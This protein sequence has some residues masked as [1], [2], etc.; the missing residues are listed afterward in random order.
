[1]DW[2]AEVRHGLARSHAAIDDGV[3]EEMAQH[4]ESAWQ[5]ARAEGAAADEA[6][7]SVR[8]LIDAWCAA[9]EGPRRVRRPP[10]LASAPASSSSS[11][12]LAGIGLDVRHA[13]RLFQ[14]QRGF[15]L[16]SILMIALGIGATATI[17]S[18]VN[19]V[20]LKPLPWPNAAQLVRVSETRRGGTVSLVPELTNATYL[21][22]IEHAQTI[23]GIAGYS[24]A[25]AILS[26]DNGA[27]RVP[28]ANVTA[29][30]FPLLGVKPLL[31]AGFTTA[32]D[33][34]PVVVL[35]YG[36]WRERFGGAADV[37]GRSLNFSTGSRTIV[38]VMPESFMFPTPAARLWLPMHMNQP[39][40]PGG[41]TTI[42]MFT[43]LAR[44]KP[45]ATPQQAAAE[46]ERAAKALPNL[47]PVIPAVFGSTGEALVSAQPLADALVG[48]V[49]P[50][51][52]ILLA[53]VILLWLA[54][55]GNV[56]S[57]QM[58]HAIARRREVAVRAAIG[59]GSLRLIRQLLVEN[60][61]LGILGG[62]AGLGLAAALL[63]ALPAFLPSDFPRAETL[64]MDGR[65]VALAVLLA[66]AASAVIAILPARLASALDLRAAIAGDAASSGGWK[67]GPARSRQLIIA[68]QV[69]IAAVLLVGGALLGRSFVNLWKLDRGFNGSNVLAARVQLPRSRATPAARTAAFAEIVSRISARPG[70]IAAG[71]SEGI[72]LTGSER[73][74]A[75]ISREPGREDITINALLRQVT[76]GYLP[77]IGMRMLAGRDLADTDNLTS[78]LV[79]VV[80]KTFAR[81]YLGEHP[82]GSILPALIDSNRDDAGKWH[83]VGVV[84]DV[85][86]GNTAETIQPEIFVNAAQL[87]TGPSASSYLTVRSSGN[88]AALAVDVREIVRAV[89]AGATIEQPMTME[90]R[91][92]KTLARPRLYAVLFA[93][94]SVFAAL[95]AVSGLFGG[96]SYGVTQRMKEIALRSA[97]GA[98]RWEIGRL[99]VGQG[100][101]MTVAGLV[102]GLTA[103]ALAS[104]LL[105]RFLFGVKSSDAWSYAGVAALM[106]LAAVVACAIPAKRAASID[107]LKGLRG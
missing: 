81:R 99:I 68:G 14:R 6:T 104:R 22:W 8:A 88:A 56:A 1:M 76:P 17:F 55:V 28:A 41:G 60:A 103:A 105:S 89:D 106:L 84:D 16:I 46:A 63:R 94:F 33:E 74:F 42:S 91:L 101:A 82:V 26:S 31:G 58:A 98:S 50:V 78:E 65:V 3:V 100:L 43:A 23:D 77:A 62:V 93:G 102:L 49:R 72:P 29:T 47:G 24:D 20:L 13:L 70:V 87:T 71:F 75:S 57:M 9:T 36:F 53:A 7:A 92:L 10:L 79:A 48:D 67:H 69:A 38:A 4:A 73:R 32:E 27:E 85:L 52:W 37:I 21:A 54:A 40:L 25:T 30:L 86:R 18:V 35:S 64:V 95:V 90:A 5:A 11:S 107:P 12:W 83:V 44:L 2:Q 51:L 66:F 15:A 61:L 80:N 34:R 45:G 97:L 39:L 59:A 19:G 96:L